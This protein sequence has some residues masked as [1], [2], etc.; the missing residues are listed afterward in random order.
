M[1]K[2]G[3]KLIAAIMSLV[4][5]VTVAVM[6]SYAWMTL[7]SNPTAEGIQ[8]TIGGGNTILIAP[9][10]TV[11]ANG[12]TYHYPGAFKDTINFSQHDSYD[13]LQSLAGLCPVSTVDGVNWILPDYYDAT[14]VEVKH[15]E[16]AGGELKP[17]SGFILDDSLSHANIPAGQTEL[18]EQGSY[19]YL[20]FWVVSPGSDY[21]L[22]VSAGDENGGSFLVGLM[23]PQETDADGDGTADS[24]TL[25]AS[26]E[27]AAA[28]ARVGFLVNP[29][30]VTDETMTFYQ[31]SAH[32]SDAYHQ[33]RGVYKDP[34]G[35]YIYSSEFRFTVY[36]PNGDVHPFGTQG[37]YTVTSPLMWDN[38]QISPMDIRDRLTVQLR[39]SWK[40]AAVGE[41]LAIEQIFQ[42]AIAGKAF[43][44][45]TPT[46]LEQDFYYNYLQSQ[47]APYVNKGQFISRTADLYAAA[48]GGTAGIE[49]MAKLETGGATQDAYIITLQKNVPQRI[50]MYIWLEGQDPDCVNEASASSFALSIE[51]AGSNQDIT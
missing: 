46:Q 9:D 31:N 39:N 15:G 11:A 50:R 34:D 47:V 41:G 20:D 16:V 7:S 44:S 14:D 40:N 29:N 1:N 4:L 43:R 36:E 48:V 10:V 45:K 2:I 12:Q 49:N 6:S 17:V 26:G 35:P 37:T 42:T 24:Y 8:I 5:A 27:S 23:R 33:L 30:N 51:L 22:R 18:A 38:H 32:F 28:C 13:Y 3:T 25:T 21:T 19:I